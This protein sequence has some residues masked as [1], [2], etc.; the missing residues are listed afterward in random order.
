MTV[1]L[2]QNIKNKIQK[3]RNLRT[4]VHER[5][6]QSPQRKP[7]TPLEIQKPFRLYVCV[8]MCPSIDS[9]SYSNKK[10]KIKKNNAHESIK[11]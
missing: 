8:C 7:L 10:N 4:S 11:D 1:N 3:W 2:K 5:L 6:E 9:T